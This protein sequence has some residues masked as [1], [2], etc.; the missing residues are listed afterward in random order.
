[1]TKFKSPPRAEEFYSSLRAS[2]VIRLKVDLVFKGRLRTWTWVCSLRKNLI[3]KNVWQ[4]HATTWIH[5]YWLNIHVR[6]TSLLNQSI[7]HLT[8][9]LA[10]FPIVL[11]PTHNPWVWY[12][13]LDERHC[14]NVKIILEREKKMSEERKRSLTETIWQP[15]KNYGKVI[16]DSRV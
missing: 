5:V 16:K 2:K 9:W 10:R 4:T 1:M 7:I 3:L 12:D 6:L 15:I 14:K 11:T 8:P 13:T